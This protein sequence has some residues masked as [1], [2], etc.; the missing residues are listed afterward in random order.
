MTRSYILKIF[1]RAQ[2]TNALPGKTP[3]GGKQIREAEAEFVD[4]ARVLRE[5]DILGCSEVNKGLD[6]S[7]RCYISRDFWH[8]GYWK[9]FH[10]TIGDRECTWRTRE[11]TVYRRTMFEVKNI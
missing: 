10:G 2:S 3:V 1:S 11:H 9:Q 8:R 6:D 7:V 4:A 5:Q